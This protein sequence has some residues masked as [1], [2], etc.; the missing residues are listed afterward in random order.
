MKQN[1]LETLF[2]GITCAHDERGTYVI[3]DQTGLNELLSRVDSDRI[4]ARTV[5]N[6]DFGKYIVL[7]AF[8]GEKPAGGYSTKITQIVEKAHSLEVTVQEH[9]S[10]GSTV[11][12]M[13]TQPY[14]I[15]KTPRIDK[16]VCFTYVRGTRAYY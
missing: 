13:M 6:V 11:I 7:A 4:P 1:K 2:E 12:T 14:H 3:R 15:V 8:M 16:D 5:P 10:D 9:E